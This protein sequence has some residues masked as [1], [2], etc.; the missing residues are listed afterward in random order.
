MSV[1]RKKNSKMSVASRH[2]TLNKFRY[3]SIILIQVYSNCNNYM[4]CL[5][6]KTGH[7]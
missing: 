5:E 4:T 1:K 6:L 2:H 7:T 3:F